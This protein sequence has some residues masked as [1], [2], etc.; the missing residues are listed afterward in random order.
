[1]NILKAKFSSRLLAFLIDIII[2]ALV[3]E[4]LNALIPKNRNIQTLESEMTNLRYSY[5]K[6]EIDST[7]YFNRYANLQRSLDQQNIPSN[8]LNVMLI[9]CYF[10]LLLYYWDGKIIGKKIL[11]IRVVKDNV[12]EKVT[13]ND[14][15]LRTITINGIACFLVSM[16]TVF[17]LDDFK[18]TL[19]VII[20]GIIQFL[21]VIT[22]GFMII[23]RHDK[24]G[25]HDL[26]SG[27]QVIK[28]G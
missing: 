28:E 11:K 12:K 4:G 15:L 24:K 16:C 5:T 27:T 21:L 23:Y 3:F 19:T 25:V 22:S 6:K 20:F 1:M 18:Y 2:V 17:I 7:V 9:L 14:F 10:V 26:I 13:L 8:I